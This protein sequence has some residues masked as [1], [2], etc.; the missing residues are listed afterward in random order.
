EACEACEPLAQHQA[1]RRHDSART[2]G[3]QSAMWI[4]ERQWLSTTAVR[5]S[6]LQPCSCSTQRYDAV[7]SSVLT[8]AVKQLYT[9]MMQ[10]PWPI[11]VPGVC[12]CPG[13]LWRPAA[14]GS[15]CPSPQRLQPV[16]G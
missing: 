14:A 3:S 2:Y 4:S 1:P 15:A 5:S 12:A 10:P 6:A 8:L 7:L 9:A 11:R 16:G 13:G